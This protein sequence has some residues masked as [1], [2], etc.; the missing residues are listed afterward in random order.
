[1][2]KDVTAL[3]TRPSPALSNDQQA[4]MLAF[5]Q[6]LFKH[7]YC[8]LC[9]QD[10]DLCNIV[11]KILPFCGHTFCLACL[12]QLHKTSVVKCPLCQKYQN[13]VSSV[14]LLPTN[15]AIHERLIRTLPKDKINPI[16]TTL[17]LPGQHIATR[18]G[19]LYVMQKTKWSLPTGL[20]LAIYTRRDSDTFT[21]RH[22]RRFPV[23]YVHK[24]IIL[25]LIV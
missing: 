12:N 13:R 16:Y 18:D 17:I 2:K 3:L 14:E 23:D 25:S 21:A 4:K 10:Y 1:M 6:K 19:R 24:I 8:I 9:Q 15:H 20:S 7:E 5:S 22:T 11:P